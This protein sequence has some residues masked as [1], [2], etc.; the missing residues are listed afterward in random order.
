MQAPDTITMF[1]GPLDGTEV[2]YYG[3][4]YLKTLTDGYEYTYDVLLI[5]TEGKVRFLAVYSGRVKSNL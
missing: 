4:K 2:N 5:P 1:G 3:A